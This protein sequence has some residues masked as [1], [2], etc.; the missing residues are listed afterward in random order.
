MAELPV[1]TNTLLSKI[2]E[3]LEAE[4][5][6]SR[7][8]HLGGSLIGHPCERFLWYMFRWCLKEEHGARLLRLFERGHLEEERFE[9][10]LNMA[11]VVFQAV[12]P[13]TGEQFRVKACKGHFGG[14]LDGLAINIPE[15]PKTEHLVEEKTH[16]DKSFKALKKKG[17]RGHKP[18]HYAQ[19]Q[20]Y[21]KLRELTRGVY[22]AINKN[23]DSI[24]VERVNADDAQGYKLLIKAEGIINATEPPL[25]MCPNQNKMEC[26]WCAF[27]G[28]CGGLEEPLKSCRS[29]VNVEPVEG[30]NW[31]CHEYKLNV[32]PQKDAEGN[33]PH[34]NDKLGCDKYKLIPAMQLD[35]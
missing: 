34:E 32:N 22:M 29:C 27:K 3:A 28:I 8:R 11:G 26:G 24:Y 16:N 31:Y 7:R 33:Y 23:D 5:E 18:Q 12:E 15:A 35:D 6:D 19:M 2:N 20:V 10:W 4:Q 1:N 9:K 25:P 17:M 13:T 14:S 30:G 21:M